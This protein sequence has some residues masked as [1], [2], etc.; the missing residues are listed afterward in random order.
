MIEEKSLVFLLIRFVLGGIFLYHGISKLGSAN[1]GWVSYMESVKIPKLMAQLAIFIEILI[2][3]TLIL[4]IFTR[5]YALL[6]LL[7]MIV[8]FYVAHREYP[9]IGEKGCSYQILIVLLCIGLLI[10]GSGKYAYKSD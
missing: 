5:F 10:T 3:I 8:A 1:V 2:G 4:G 6:G 9:L 7:F